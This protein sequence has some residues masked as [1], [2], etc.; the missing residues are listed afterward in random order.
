MLNN[1]I[2]K[3]YYKFFICGFLAGL[4]FSPTYFI[5]FLPFSFYF[6]ITKI[7][8]QKQIKQVI[9]FSLSFSF[10][11]YLIQFYWISFSLF[12]DKKFLYLLPFSLTI[13]PIVCSIYFI[14]AIIC[15]YKT[16]NYFNIKN[17]FLVTVI[18]SFFYVI[19]EYLRGY[20]FP[21]NIF[22]YTLGFSLILMQ[23][24]YLLNIYFI[25]FILIV[26]Y[27]FSY[28]LFEYKNK[29]LIFINKNYTFIYIFIFL[30]IFIYGLIRLNEKKQTNNYNLNIRLVQS[31]IKQNVKVDIENFYNN[32]QKHID[33]TNKDNLKDVDIIIWSESSIPFALTKEV[34]LPSNFDFLENKILITG[35]IRYDEY[36]DNFYNSI[37]IFK[38]SKV[39]DFYDKNIL[40]PFGEY[41]PFSKYIPF[42]KKIVGE[43]YNFS[44]GTGNKTININN[45]IKISPIICYESI[46]HKK[47][48]DK[49]NKPNLI[50]NLT[51]DAWF[52]YS[53][54]P[55]QHFTITR[56]RAIENKI[57]IVRVANTG[58]T[59]YID[60]YGRI[61]KKTKLNEEKIIDVKI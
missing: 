25:S 2:V 51:N 17:K 35:A 47:I 24:S 8:E 42:I 60:E 59:A 37:F 52:G 23:I 10:F 1:N 32:I 48:Y 34:I 13:I 12:V 20:I 9:Y 6:F 21:W 58:I 43:F 46:F 53:S 44:E 49:K 29:K 27:S 5:F 36:F 56:F 40:V 15:F 30:F 57:P 55:F 16:I 4:S 31:N 14:L 54:G 7:L 11:Y 61:I 3:K 45:K 18:F 26:F 33:L 39:Y 19:F 50:V 41:V 22:T 28:V 38:D